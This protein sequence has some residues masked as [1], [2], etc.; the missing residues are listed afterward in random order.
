MI[1]KESIRSV[2]WATIEDFSGLWEI[3]WELNSVNLQKNNAKLAISILTYL[4]NNDL[5]QLYRSKWG[6]DEL[7]KIQKVEAILLLHKQDSWLIP[8]IGEICIRAGSTQKGEDYYNN[9]KI[10]NV[11]IL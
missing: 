4:L 9:D 7:S 2:L 11:D 1:L 6:E 8:R 3:V 10:A 5:I